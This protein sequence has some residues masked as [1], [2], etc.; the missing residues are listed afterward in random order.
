MA[1]EWIGEGFFFSICSNPVIQTSSTPF[2]YE[3]IC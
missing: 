3:R 2:P 1:D